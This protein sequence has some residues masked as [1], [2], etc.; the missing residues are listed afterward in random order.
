MITEL[1]ILIIVVVLTIS[2][3]SAKHYEIVDGL[4]Y[5][6]PVIQSE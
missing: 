4:K 2:K 3:I 5:L 6:I 1:R